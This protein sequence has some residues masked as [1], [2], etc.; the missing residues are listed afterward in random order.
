VSRATVTTTTGV[1]VVDSASGVNT[2]VPCEPFEAWDDRRG[3]RFLATAYHCDRQPVARWYV[4]GPKLNRD[5]SPH[6]GGQMGTQPVELADVPEDVRRAV[7]DHYA[8][9]AEAYRDHFL[10]LALEVAPATVPSP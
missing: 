9:M 5:G 8:A 6:G 7:A 10:G 1:F 4:G 2:K 3:W